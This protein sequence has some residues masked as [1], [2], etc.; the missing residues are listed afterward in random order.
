MPLSVLSA[1][2]GSA[3]GSIRAWLGGASDG[4]PRHGQIGG[5]TCGSQD[6]LGEDVNPDDFGDAALSEQVVQ[7]AHAAPAA[8]AT[9]A[10]ALAP[11]AA[12]PA[13]GSDSPQVSPPATP[14]R[15]QPPA[16]AASP[17]TPVDMPK[18]VSRKRAAAATSQPSPAA[19]PSEQY[20]DPF[21]AMERYMD[22]PSVAPSPASSAAKKPAPKKPATSTKQQCKRRKCDVEM[23]GEEEDRFT[24]WDKPGR[25]RFRIEEEDAALYRR[26]TGCKR[27]SDAVRMA[28]KLLEAI[29]YLQQR[30]V[31]DK[32]L[33]GAELANQLKAKVDVFLRAPAQREEL[34]QKCSSLERELPDLR[35]ANREK[36]RQIAQREEK[37]AQLEKE[38]MQLNASLRA[39]R[40][41]NLEEE[42]E[43]LQNQNAALQT[44]VDDLENK[45]SRMKRNWDLELEREA[46]VW[47]KEE[48]MYIKE[49]EEL[50]AVI[51]YLYM[52]DV[53][54]R[55]PRGL[56]SQA[57]PARFVL[58]S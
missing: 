47:R 35:W 17:A 30:D 19:A 41:K 46:K 22:D 31:L 7:P 45:V 26:L 49:V 51:E 55:E 32:G 58:H 8:H 36:Q 37:I 18:R 42:C 40:V 24:P 39:T 23:T 44:K 15:T 21:V 1:K 34:Q 33:T 12:E 13:G 43:E 25:H 4:R 29:E 53:L 54:M 6:D 16:A 50:E 11:P 38:M 10:V 52:R 14:P 57:R 2:V 3:F 9:A 5:S 28:S 48:R 56:G 27:V 20:E